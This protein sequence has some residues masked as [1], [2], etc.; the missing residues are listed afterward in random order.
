MSAANPSA[1][2]SRPPTAHRLTITNVID[3]SEIPR[4]VDSPPLAGAG[5][6]NWPTAGEEKV[7]LY[8]TARAEANRVQGDLTV[9][10]F[11]RP[12]PPI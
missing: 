11:A 1:R 6:G 9:R 8:E 3:D 12:L 5:R 7:H 2:A 4:D 10:I